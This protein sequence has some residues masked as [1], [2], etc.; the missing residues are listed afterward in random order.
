MARHRDL[1][2]MWRRWCAQAPKS[3]LNTQC[4]SLACAPLSSANSSSLSASPTLCYT[5]NFCGSVSHSSS[6][7]RLAQY[8]KQK[9]TSSSTTLPAPAAGPCQSSPSHLRPLAGVAHN[10][11]ADGQQS[12]AVLQVGSAARIPTPSSLDRC[13]SWPHEC[14][15]P[16]VLLFHAFDP[17]YTRWFLNLSERAGGCWGL[18]GLREGRGWHITDLSGS[19]STLCPSRAPVKRELQRRTT[20]HWDGPVDASYRSGERASWLR[21]ILSCRFQ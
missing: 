17:A 8:C 11:H 21:L 4:A 5:W 18:E 6:W 13:T 3:S 12:L 1:R 9:E 15:M 20:H 14:Y 19:S 16:A 7:E 10:A 2:D